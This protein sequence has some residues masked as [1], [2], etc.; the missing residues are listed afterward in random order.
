MIVAAALTLCSCGNSGSG[1]ASPTATAASKKNAVVKSTSVP[2]ATLDPNLK[3]NKTNITI[4]FEDDKVIKAELY[5]DIAPISVANFV[6]LANEHFYDGL[7]F[8]RV[9]DGFMIQGGGYDVDLNKKDSPAIKGEFAENGVKNDLSHKRGVLSMARTQAVDSAS[10]Q[11][12]I[13]QKD[14]TY[15]D[16]K[17]AAFGMVT[18]GLDVVDEIAKCKTRSD[19]SKGLDNIPETPVV[20][21]TIT[22]D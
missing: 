1:K 2:V 20:I 8:H 21:K 13:V 18:E 9:I 15:L 16:G 3:S 17:Y 10:S 19:T 4:T 6:K 7:I 12:F 22:V 14:S 5:P 11:F